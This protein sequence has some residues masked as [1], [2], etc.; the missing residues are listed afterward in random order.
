MQFCAIPQ[1]RFYINIFYPPN[2]AI[3]QIKRGQFTFLHVTSE[4]IYKIK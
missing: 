4:R 2:T 3:G 1:K